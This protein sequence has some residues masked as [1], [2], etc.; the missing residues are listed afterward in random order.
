MSGGTRRGY[1]LRP[2]LAESVYYMSVTTQSPTW[3][4]A[5]KDI[6]DSITKVCRVRCGFASIQDI[7][8]KSLHDNMPSFFL[9]E[10]LKYLYLLFDTSNF[11]REDVGGN[12]VFTTEAHLI[13]VRLQ[14]QQ[15]AREM[16]FS[17]PA[18]NTNKVQVLPEGKEWGVPSLSAEMIDAVQCPKPSLESD[19]TSEYF[20]SDP[21]NRLGRHVGYELET[22]IDPVGH[23]PSEGDED[24][25]EDEGARVNYL[26]ANDSDDP[27]W[28]KVTQDS[29]S[30][31]ID[32][33]GSGECLEITNL[34]TKVATIRLVRGKKSR[35]IFL[36]TERSEFSFQ[37]I[38]VI[39]KD[40]SDSCPSI[41]LFLNTDQS[42]AIALG[43]SV[44]E[45]GAENYVDR[46]I[47]APLVLAAQPQGC[48]AEAYPPVLV[49]DKLVVVHRG[50]CMFEEKAK[51]AEASGALG[52]IVIQNKIEEPVFF[53]SRMMIS[54]W[55]RM[56]SSRIS[57][58]MVTKSQG[59]LIENDLKRGSQLRM[60]IA[61]SKVTNKDGVYPWGG[62][63]KD[64][65]TIMA[66]PSWGVRMVKQGQ[67]WSLMI[68]KPNE[69][70]SDI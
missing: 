56:L 59:E 46:S 23:M 6:L 50:A 30:F 60:D 40:A 12:Y 41:N 66:S 67:T 1:P 53:M 14:Y 28:Y 54:S 64:K 10:L 22:R 44:S 42:P 70:T 43:L 29:H 35:M 39:S 57:C 4:L 16:K 63:Y 3:F 26:R 49:R 11:V 61:V 25:D 34:G 52:V 48:Y 7:K 51:L 15:A 33:E 20:A 19:T 24:S 38:G 32:K 47:N 65:L 8:K 62:S 21:R 37:A 36:D 45:F 13:P 18:R 31:L 55:F 27:S 69:K 2:E 68:L 9:S 5:G 58:F 17:F